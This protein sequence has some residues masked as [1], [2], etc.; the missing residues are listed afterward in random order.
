[1]RHLALGEVGIFHGSYETGFTAAFPTSTCSPEARPRSRGVGA[2]EIGGKGV[3]V[4]RSRGAVLSPGLV[5]LH[6]DPLFEHLSMT[7]QPAALVGKLAALV[8]DLRLGPIQFDPTVVASAPQAKRL[9]RLLRFVATE[10]EASLMPAVMQSEL[11]QAMMTAFLLANASNTAKSCWASPSRRRRGQVCV[12]EQFIEAHWDQP[13]TIE[14]L[15]AAANVSARSLFSAFKGGR[16]YSPME[17]VKRVRLGR[18]RQKLSRPDGVTSVTAVAFECGF[19][20]PGHFAK[21]Y[22][23]SFGETPSE[24]LRRGLGGRATSGTSDG[25]GS[26]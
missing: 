10:F 17:F 13:I 3:S 9:E 16:G 4:S 8:G 6:Y 15:A 2:H 11:Q 18:A 26:A 1:M 22:R 20:N 12:A 24:T 7:V 5:R 23:E 21:D 25:S 19:G 14:A